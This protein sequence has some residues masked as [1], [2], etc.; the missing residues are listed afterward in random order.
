MHRERGRMG[1]RSHTPLQLRWAEEWPLDLN[2]TQAAIRAG[3]SPK[4]ATVAGT[5]MLANVSLMAIAHGHIEARSKRT[6]ITSDQVLQE[7]AAIGFADMGDYITI[8]ENGTPMI[9]FSKLPPDGSQV[10]KKIK[11]KMFVMTRSY[12]EGEGVET[13]ITRIETEFELHDK[14]AALVNMGKHLGMF[15]EKGGELPRERPVLMTDDQIERLGDIPGMP[16]MRDITP[17]EKHR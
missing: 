12:D 9:D 16:P 6:G 13:T 17:R 7:L 15:K 2:A 5:R 14:I 8:M 10:V 1:S 4:G 3:Y 11:Q